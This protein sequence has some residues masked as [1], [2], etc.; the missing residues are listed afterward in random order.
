MREARIYD[1]S[2]FGKTMPWLAIK[3]LNL[4]VLNGSRMDFNQLD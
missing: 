3:Y 4:K 2:F 1:S